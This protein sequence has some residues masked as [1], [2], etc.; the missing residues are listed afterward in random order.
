MSL[1]R[2]NRV[3]LMSCVV[4]CLAA[5]VAFG[6][7]PEKYVV[8]VQTDHSDALYAVNQ[9]A[10][11]TITVTEAGKAVTEGEVKVKLSMDYGKAIGEEK[12]LKL[13]AEPLKMTGTLGEPGFLNCLVTFAKEGKTYKGAA[14][15]GFDPQAI[16]PACK[17][18]AD[19][20]AFWQAGIE[21]LG[22]VPM[23]AQVTAM[24]Q[25][26]N[27]KHD[28]F[29]VSFANVGNS[30]TYGFLCVPKGK[31]GPYPAMLF[32]PSAGLVKPTSPTEPEWADRGVLYFASCIQ[33][34]DPMNPPKDIEK[35]LD[36]TVIGAPDRDKYYFRQVILGQYRA[37][38]YLK[39]RSDFDGKHMV[40]SSGSQGGGLA[41]ML[42][43]LNPH[44]TAICLTK[45]AM[46]DHQAPLAGRGIPWP[47]LLR[48][49]EHRTEE[50]VKMSE[51]YD[52]VNFAR[53]ITIPVL[54]NV[55]FIDS[56]C[57]PSTGYAA[58]NVIPGANKT[59]MNFVTQEH[60]WTF[61]DEAN[62]WWRI[63]GRW[64]N[65]QFGFTPVVPPAG[66][67]GPAKP[68]SAN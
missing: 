36:Y 28:T 22:K 54:A 18:P 51:Y 40:I 19:F 21:E 34:F 42:G 30:R 6:A 66:I 33:D 44:V 58:Y 26:S 68:A 24:P 32:P 29:Y 37:I 5:W 46:C 9:E 52:A 16:K 35:R 23:D 47:G 64:L 4:L 62:T 57:P 31:K 15:G 11:F 63:E 56:T 50:W 27:E 1:L 12:T 61:N 41:L 38:E 2:G 43:A 8:K 10:S 60:F 25:F 67:I 45:P 13:G 53:K 59:M 17:L 3:G 14:A 55:G 7:E 39:N 48:P 65:G 20:D 49:A